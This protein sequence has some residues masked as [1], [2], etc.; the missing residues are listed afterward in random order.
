MV[1]IC[2]IAVGVGGRCR[3]FVDLDLEEGMQRSR[4]LVD[5]THTLILSLDDLVVLPIV[6]VLSYSA[7]TTC[8]VRGPQRRLYGTAVSYYE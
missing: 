2:R 6:Q 7:Y 5:S 8:S 4:P 3:N 1:A